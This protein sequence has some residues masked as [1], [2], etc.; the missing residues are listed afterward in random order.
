MAKYPQSLFKIVSKGATSEGINASRSP[1]VKFFRISRFKRGKNTE[2]F[3]PTLVVIVQG[4]K[5]MSFEGGS[6]THDP[7]TFFLTSSECVYDL[8]IEASEEMPYLAMSID[9]P[10]DVISEVFLRSR[11]ERSAISVS[12]ER[13]F[14]RRMSPRLRACV[15]RLSASAQD[16]IEDSL[17]S[18]IFVREI[19]SHLFVEGAGSF[20]AEVLKSRYDTSR[21]KN[22]MD[23]MKAN[24]ASEITISSLAELA[25][26][27]TSNFAHRFSEIAGMSPM[28]Y[29][30]AVR[31]NESARLLMNREFNISEVADRVGYQS[32][33][34]F[35]HDFKR[36]HGSTPSSFR[37]NF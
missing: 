11:L 15:T 9:L 36:F 10:P 26:M 20:F 30:K 8:K 37:S 13:I 24:F 4:M 22:V 28:K 21:L 29:L 16:P 32:L 25:G 2:F 27:G 7:K 23:H 17:F 33:S 34:H 6:L 19:I 1:G 3:G 35:V 14:V 12:D 18:D 31:L 5:S